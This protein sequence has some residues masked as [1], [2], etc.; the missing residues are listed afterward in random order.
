M[1][2]IDESTK[3]FVIN[4]K[5]DSENQIFLRDFD[6]EKQDEIRRFTGD[7]ETVAKKNK[8]FNEAAR[9][10][11]E[12]QE[13]ARQAEK[14]YFKLT[15]NIL[16]KKTTHNGK[17]Y[18]PTVRVLDMDKANADILQER[19]KELLASQENFKEDVSVF[20][21]KYENLIKAQSKI[22]N[23]SAEDDVFN[24]DEEK[25]KRNSL[26]SNYETLW[27]EVTTEQ[28][29]LNQL[30]R[31]LFKNINSFQDNQ[32]IDA[33]ILKN[34][35]YGHKL[36]HVMEEAFLGST[37]MLGSSIA[38]GIGDLSIA[39][40]IIDKE[41]SWYQGRVEGKQNAIDY[42]RQL[43]EYR[44]IYLPDRLT[45]A[46]SSSKGA[47][48][49]DML[50]ENSPSILVAAGTMGYG[51]IAAAGGGLAA[52]IAATK[53]AANVA[54]AIFFTMEAGG[55]MSNLEISQ[56]DAKKLLDVNVPGNLIS[57]LEELKQ[58]NIQGEIG[59][60]EIKNLEQQIE[61]QKNLANLT[62]VQK[63][64]NSIAYGGIASG[65]ER[66][67]SLR[68][69]NNFQKYSRAVGGNTFRKA[70]GDALGCLLYTSDAA[71]E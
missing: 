4:K 18:D 71:D 5:K 64:F 56:Q 25:A 10:K 42:N 29:R 36:A 21:E 31:E 19:E 30:E 2:S 12:S 27:N 13:K 33:A 23:Y 26:L 46:D 48:L 9:F 14:E 53:A 62:Q 32:R 69:I 61:D 51:S 16:V 8:L 11:L 47:Y 43:Q 20:K 60:F 49:A 41:N 1:D 55:Q 44:N 35:E 58:K 45:A 37:E 52:R 70:F 59:V 3:T 63:S 24:T 34:Y 28:G 68:F 66:F 40:G 22:I 39:T 50:I 17:V 65:A 7:K 38:K 54:T 6:E 15:G 67:G 57:Q